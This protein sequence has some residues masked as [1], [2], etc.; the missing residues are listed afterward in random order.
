V[1]VTWQRFAHPVYPQRYASL[2]F[3]PNLAALDLLFN[4]GPDAAR[5]LREAMQPEP[6]AAE[7]RT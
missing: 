6:P 7:V 4:C 5:I 1:H 3:K 2:G